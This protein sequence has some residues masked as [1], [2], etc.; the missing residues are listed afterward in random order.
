MI[1][2]HF[3]IFIALS[4]AVKDRTNLRC[5]KVDSS[6]CHDVLIGFFFTLVRGSIYPLLL[7][8]LEFVDFKQMILL[9]QYLKESI[10]STN[11]CP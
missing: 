1:D 4:L 8:L 7:L 5:D 11:I 10:S 9:P 6:W 3:I 2:V